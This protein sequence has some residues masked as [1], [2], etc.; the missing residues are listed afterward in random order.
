[1]RGLTYDKYTNLI[2]NCSGL[3]PIGK[4]I[5]GKIKWFKL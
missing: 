3:Y 1:M 2:Y 5:N 4:N